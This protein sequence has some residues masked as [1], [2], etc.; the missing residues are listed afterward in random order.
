M[1]KENLV[2]GIAGSS[3]VGKDTFFKL[4]NGL[5][6][7]SKRFALA[8]KLKEE[9]S[10]P[11]KK[12]Y[13]IDIFNCTSEEKSLIRPLMVKHG[14]DRREETKGRYWIDHLTPKI[15][16]YHSKNPKGIAFITDLR[17]AFYDKDELEWLKEELNGILIYIDRYTEHKEYIHP[18]FQTD[19]L[20]PKIYKKFIF[21]ANNLER[22]NNLILRQK[23][24]YRIEWPTVINEDNNS[25]TSLNIY[26]EEFIRWLSR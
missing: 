1:V 3:F 6:P 25:L 13:G 9:I 19:N 12:E 26:A 15:K 17:F 2:I 21:P 11:I 8:D 18:D 10:G 16:D 5:Y 7:N 24:D 23:S 14:A 22:D 4:F 20:I